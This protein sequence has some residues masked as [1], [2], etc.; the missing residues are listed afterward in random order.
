MNATEKYAVDNGLDL[1]PDLEIT[2]TYLTLQLR[3][4]ALGPSALKSIT[5]RLSIPGSFT[6]PSSCRVENSMKTICY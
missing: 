1:R 5:Q 2:I 6:V 3:S 4:F